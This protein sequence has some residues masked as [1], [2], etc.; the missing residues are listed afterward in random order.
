[1]GVD[2]LSTITRF[3]GHGTSLLFRD[4]LRSE[5][6][7]RDLCERTK[8]ALIEQDWPDMNAHATAKTGVIAEIKE[9]ARKA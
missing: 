5:P 7:D 4:H 3:G 1:M 8:R 6:E 9:R 2:R